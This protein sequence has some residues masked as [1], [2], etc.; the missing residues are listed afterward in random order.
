MVNTW[1]WYIEEASR[2]PIPVGDAFKD[3]EN[4]VEESNS[5]PDIMRSGFERTLKDLKNG[6][7]PEEDK[8]I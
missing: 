1:K 2:D 3:E 7:A 8:I 5:G 6:K 4:Q